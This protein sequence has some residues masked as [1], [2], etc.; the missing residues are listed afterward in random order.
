MLEKGLRFSKFFIH[1]IAL[2]IT[3]AVAGVNLTTVYGWDQGSLHILDNKANNLLQFAAK[4]HEI[5][6]VGSL[7]SIVVHRIRKR[8]VSS[9]G[10]PFGL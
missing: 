10:L 4:L 5:V 7:T 6:I 8:L 2:V 3:A 9:R 1:I